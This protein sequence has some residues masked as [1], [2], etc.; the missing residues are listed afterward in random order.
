MNDVTRSILN[1]LLVP[2]IHSHQNVQAELGY[3]SLMR[4]GRE[5]EVV[6]SGTMASD[7]SLLA[8][9]VVTADIRLIRGRCCTGRLWVSIFIT[10]YVH[11]WARGLNLVGLSQR[12]VFHLHLV[13]P[14]R[15]G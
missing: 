15:P 13:L 9:D 7:P 1:G 6:R 14:N 5:G 12:P 2:F 8:T 3:C 10:E 11:W 4:R